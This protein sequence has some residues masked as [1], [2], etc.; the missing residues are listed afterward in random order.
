MRVLV[1]AIVILSCGGIVRAEIDRQALVRRHNVKVSKLDALSPLSVGN[2][3][4]AFTMDV[5]GLQTFPEAYASG[6]QLGTQSHWAWHTTPAT[7]P[8][9]R[10]DA[11]DMVDAHGR[12]APYAAKQRG[13]AGTYFRA[14]PHPIDLGRVG[15][16]MKKEDG[17]AV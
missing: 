10:E 3:E 17:S 14:N 16:R 6:I 13:A 7:Q 11:D 2:G 12:K 8:V 9:K 5:T 1:L 4:F 15:L